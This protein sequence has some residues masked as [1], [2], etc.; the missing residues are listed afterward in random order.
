MAV[1]DVKPSWSLLRLLTDLE[2]QGIYLV[3]ESEGILLMIGENDVY[4][5]SCVTVV[6]YLSKKR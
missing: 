1:Y 3:R 6:Y 4:C 5:L 2:S